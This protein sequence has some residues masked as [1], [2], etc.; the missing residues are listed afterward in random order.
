MPEAKLEL[1]IENWGPV[2]RGSIEVKPLTVFIGPNNTGKSYVAMLLYALS[3]SHARLLSQWGTR[4]EEGDVERQL[5]EALKPLLEHPGEEKS[6]ETL[7]K[8][9]S[10]MGEVLSKIASRELPRRLQ[11]E[12]ERV[13]SSRLSELVRHGAPEASIEVYLKTPGCKVS[14]NYHVAGGSLN[15]KTVSISFSVRFLKRQVGKYANRLRLLGIRASSLEQGED[16]IAPIVVGE[17]LPMLSEA[18][19]E[20]IFGGRIH[21]IPASRAGVLYSYRSIAAALVSIA[22]LAPL[23]GVEVP[24]VPGPL[25]DF[26]SKLLLLEP[27][28]LFKEP[29]SKILAEKFEK[30]ILGGEI[31]LER[32]EVPEAPPALYFTLNDKRVPITRVS[33]MLAEAAPLALFLKYGG[34]GPGDTLIVEEPEAHLHPDKQ[35]KMAE[36]LAL[37]VNHGVRV[38]VTTHSDVL[39]AKLSNL[40]SLSS[41][42]Q[43]SAEK[44]G[45]DPSAALKPSDVAVYSFKQGP[46]GAV[47]ERVAVTE[48][49]IPDDEFRRIEEDLYEETMNIYYQ[50]QELRGRGGA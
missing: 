2:R 36:L 33:S 15:L 44:L 35:A 21:Y 9:S 46:E 42:P 38:I 27:H 28:D 7:G 12:L 17:L 29:A 4:I 41:L 3:L 14:E 30:E 24:G 6:E 22:P 25:A 1:S 49:G 23:R 40:V 19:T 20:S 16:S 43:G 11:A 18:F 26:L 13:Y 37:L 47:V 34:I 45:L 10:L 5:L 31:V 39:I 32:R 50:L 48:E 8:L